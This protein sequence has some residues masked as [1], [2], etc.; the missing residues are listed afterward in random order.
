MHLV[1]D[2]DNKVRA[3]A[4]IVLCR[5]EVEETDKAHGQVLCLGVLQ[6]L[7]N[8]L[9]NHDKVVLKGSSKESEVR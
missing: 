1:G 6:T 4:L 7:E 9:H 5:D 2:L 3:V 8:D